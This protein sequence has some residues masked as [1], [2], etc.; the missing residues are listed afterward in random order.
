MFKK[1]FTLF[2]AILI[3]LLSAALFRTFLH[4][5]SQAKS[6][7]GDVILIDEI[8]AIENLAESIK[9]K[10]ISYQEIEMFPSTGV[11]FILLNGQQK[12]IQN[13]IKY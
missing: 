2:F 10:T 6:T 5:P 13:F 9:F 7:K 4:T 8:R 12:H 3:T 1:I 11:R